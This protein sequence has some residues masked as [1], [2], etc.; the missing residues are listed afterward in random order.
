MTIGLIQRDV[1]FQVVTDISTFFSLFSQRKAGLLLCYTIYSSI[2][3][4]FLILFKI[5]NIESELFE[6]E[7]TANS[8]LAQIPSNEQGRLQLDQ[9][10]QSPVQSDLE[11]LQGIH[12]LLSSLC[13][14]YKTMT[15]F[16]SHYVLQALPFLL[17]EKKFHVILI[18][19][20]KK[21]KCENFSPYVTSK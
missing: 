5:H 6:L 12:L 1:E 17:E 9:T 10:A 8:H 7:G 13:Q 3:Q 4:S 18:M 14:S 20:M 19:Q 2:Q 11:Y 16:C 21:S 15:E